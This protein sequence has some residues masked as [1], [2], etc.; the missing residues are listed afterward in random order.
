MRDYKVWAPE[1]VDAL[2]KYYPK[3]GGMWTGWAY[4]L[5]YRTRRAI[6]Q[7]AYTLGIGTVA[8]GHGRTWSE[9]ETWLLNRYWPEH[10]Y[11]WEGW[12]YVLPERSRQSIKDKADYDGLEPV[13]KR[14]A[15]DDAPQMTQKQRTACSVV[16]ERL[17]GALGVSVSETLDM[18][19]RCVSDAQR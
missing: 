6:C 19:C 15:V 9:D 8:I 4:V 11:L 18:L 16:L 13:H 2:K 3:R 10:G 17:S 14:D 1:E 12:D 7:K 5:P